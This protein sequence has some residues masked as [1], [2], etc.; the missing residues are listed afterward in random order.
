MKDWVF[1]RDNYT[2]IQLLTKYF[3]SRQYIFVMEVETLR[4]EAS[5]TVEF[6]VIVSVAYYI[7]KIFSTENI[8]W[9]GVMMG[10]L[11]H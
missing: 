7:C 10:S 9:E 4:I 1:E 3:S 11:W 5:N 6:P 8:S 2:R